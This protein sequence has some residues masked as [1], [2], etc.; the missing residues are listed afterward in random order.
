MINPIRK[1]IDFAS[2]FLQLVLHKNVDHTD[3]NVD[4]VDCCFAELET[5]AWRLVRRYESFGRR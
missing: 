2:A 1:V 4:I 3:S 5:E